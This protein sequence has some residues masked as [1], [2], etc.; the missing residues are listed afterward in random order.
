M[1]LELGLH[2]VD[3]ERVQIAL[4][5]FHAEQRLGRKPH[6][7]H[8]QLPARSGGDIVCENTARYVP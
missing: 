4:D 2:D 3:M 6:R 1:V 8:L 5:V 7:V